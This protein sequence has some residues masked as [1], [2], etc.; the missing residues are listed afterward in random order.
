[1]MVQYSSSKCTNVGKNWTLL[2]LQIMTM[3]KENYKN[4]VFPGTN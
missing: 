1:M 4:F 2:P 3:A